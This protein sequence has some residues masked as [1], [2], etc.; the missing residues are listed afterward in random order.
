MEHSILAGL[1]GRFGY[2]KMNKWDNTIINIE[3]EKEN[4]EN[5]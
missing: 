2:A 4:T 3:M 5:K 1:S